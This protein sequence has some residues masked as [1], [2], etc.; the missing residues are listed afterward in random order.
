MSKA[1]KRPVY[2]PKG[3]MRGHVKDDVFI[4]FPH[5]NSYSKK[6]GPYDTP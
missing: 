5:G 4:E 6:G 3:D 2:S 1:V